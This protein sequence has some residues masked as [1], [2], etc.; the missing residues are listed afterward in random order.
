MPIGKANLKQE[1]EVF[2]ELDIFEI[3]LLESRV[4]NISKIYIKNILRNE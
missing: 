2:F 4:Y 3:R 1:K